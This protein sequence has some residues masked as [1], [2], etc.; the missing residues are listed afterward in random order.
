MLHGGAAVAKTPPLFSFFIKIPL[1]LLSRTAR[2]V[3]RPTPHYP[4]PQLTPIPAHTFSMT[5]RLHLCTMAL[6]KNRPPSP[7]APPMSNKARRRARR[8]SPEA[9]LKH[10]LDMCSRDG[11]VVEALRLYD[12]ARANGVALSL[13]HYNVMLYMCSCDGEDADVGLTRG[14]E[15]FRQ[16][17]EDEVVP[18]EATFTNAARLSAVAEDPEMAFSMVKQM[19]VFG[20]LPKLRSYGPA[21]FGFCKKGE[22]ERAYE[23]D[24][25]MVECG[26]AAEETEIAALLRI[27]SEVGKGEKVYE[28]MQRLRSGVRQVGESTAEVV[29]EWFKSEAA[30]RVGVEGWDVKKVREGV[31]RGGGGWHGEGWLGSG[32]WK[33]ERTQMDEAG[34]CSAC[35]QKLVCIDIDPKE[36]ED[37]ALSVSKLANQ[38]ELRAD[39]VQ[40]Q[41]WLQRHGP[42]DAI[43]D[44]ANVGLSNQHQF[45]FFQLNNVVNQLQQMSPAKRLPLV[46]LHQSRTNGGPAQIPKNKALLESWKKSRALYATPPGSNDDWYWL[47]AAVS[48]KGLLVT[49]DEMRD[50]LFQ[51]LG[52]NFFPRWKEKHQV[53]LSVSRLG[54]SLHMPPPYSIVIQESEDGC[55]HVPT[56]TGDDIETPRQWLC[57]SR[58]RHTN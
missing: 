25:H 49:N 11:L 9:V 51:L 18:N 48:C 1:P 46:I 50:H 14:F 53:R 52:T 16:M 15:I 4:K 58:A 28:M 20:I 30:A 3:F 32:E 6:P 37:F 54:L 7:A 21:L 31:A 36:T 10:K 23:V 8:E 26:V 27:S 42:F 38:R 45:S 24:A 13:H 57:A 56:T 12:E 47:Y 29:E 2:R 19:K 55:W 41:E 33:V 39:F 5:Q 44:G 35:G 17:V 40:F 43:I 22:A 34:T